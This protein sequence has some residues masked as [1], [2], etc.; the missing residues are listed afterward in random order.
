MHDVHCNLRAFIP[1]NTPFSLYIE[2]TKK[3]NYF[4]W[5]VVDTINLDIVLPLKASFN[6]FW[7]PA[8]S[9]GHKSTH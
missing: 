8:T 9:T 6:T 2:N 1:I 5:I 4:L 7:M 3:M